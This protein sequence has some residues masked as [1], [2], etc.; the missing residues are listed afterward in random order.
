[1]SGWACFVVL[2]RG[3]LVRILLLALLALTL[4]ALTLFLRLIILILF[5]AHV[6]HLP[7]A[8]YTMRGTHE[9]TPPPQM[10]W[11]GGYSVR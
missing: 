4:L 6:V 2:L 10:W 5:G 9:R 3:R 1:M 7:S 8:I 11:G